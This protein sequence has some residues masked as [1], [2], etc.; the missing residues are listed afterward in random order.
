MAQSRSSHQAHAH[1]ARIRIAHVIAIAALIGLLLVSLAPSK[2]VAALHTNDSAGLSSRWQWPL[3]T[4]QLTRPFVAPANEYAAG[5]RG[6]DLRAI[7]DYDVFSP[8]EGTVAFVGSVA[9]RG[10]LTI[11]HG[12]GLVTTL[13]PIS[14]DLHAGD[15]ISVGEL[16]GEVGSGGH[17]AGGELHV[18]LRLHG[19]YINPQALFGAVARAVLLPCCD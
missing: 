8:A 12:G 17:A 4:F 1:F 14:T 9:H 16:V 11:D 7:G 3:R 2:A 6:V 13:E 5:H 19:E 10:V 15:V 18:G